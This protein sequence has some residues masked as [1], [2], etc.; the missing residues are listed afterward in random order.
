MYFF[1]FAKGSTREA[2]LKRLN[3]PIFETAI[4]VLEM[5]LRTPQQRLHYDARLKWELD[6]NTR[7]QAA[8]E[9]GEA[10]GKI[11]G[12]IR[13]IRTLEDLLGVQPSPESA[14]RDKSLEQLQSYSAQLQEKIRKRAT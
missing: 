9:E 12:E 5:I 1:H 13:L 4:G 7:I 8:L 10:R 3:D 2:L 11:K 6:E 14:F